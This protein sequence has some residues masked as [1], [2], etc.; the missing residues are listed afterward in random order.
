MDDIVWLVNPRRDSLHELF[1]RLKDSYAELFSAQ[2]GLFR[3]RWS[4]AKPFVP[5]GRQAKVLRKAGTRDAGPCSPTGPKGQAV[6]SAPGRDQ[7][8]SALYTRILPGRNRKSAQ[9]AL[10]RRRL[11]A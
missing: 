3:V 9:T 4:G 1:V 8:E 6:R 2:G 7:A 5:S 10:S 11:G